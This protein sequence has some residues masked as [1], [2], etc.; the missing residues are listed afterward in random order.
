M[1]SILL[2]LQVKHFIVDFLMQP[3]WMWKNKGNL[4]HYGGYA[5]AGLHAIVSYIIFSLFCESYLIGMYCALEFA[6]HY[7]TDFGKVNIQKFT[8]W[9]PSTSPYYW[10]LLGFD[11]FCHQLWYVVMIYILT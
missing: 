2:A 8:G 5:H 4:L 6:A 10:W 7:I 1:I 3:P 11:Q 9:M